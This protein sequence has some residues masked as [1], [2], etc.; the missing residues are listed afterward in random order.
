VPGCGAGCRHYNI[1]V[2]VISPGSISSGRVA[3]H[4]RNGLYG[5]E[6]QVIRTVIA[7]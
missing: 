2:N 3:T 6:A 5:A 7:E 1:N 4:T